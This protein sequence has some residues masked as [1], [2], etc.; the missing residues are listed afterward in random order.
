MS[1]EVWD[2]GTS[3]RIASFRRQGELSDWLVRLAADQG[4]EA[5][6]GLV[7]D[8]SS[9]ASAVGAQRWLFVRLSAASRP[10]QRVGRP[11]RSRRTRRVWRPMG[12]GVLP[13]TAVLFG[14]SLLSQS[15]PAAVT[16]LVA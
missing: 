10:A 15:L 8:G 3:N 7:V 12:R 2:T 13:D 11:V 14:S 1:F 16:E 6:E 5:L 4:L 9:K